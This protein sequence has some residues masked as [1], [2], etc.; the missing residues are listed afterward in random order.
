MRLS[1]LLW[2]LSFVAGGFA[3]VYYTIIRE[4]QLPLIAEAIRGVDA[5]RSDDVY[6]SAADIVYWSGFAIMVTILLIQITLLVSF[7][8]RR[9][10]IRWWQL[11]TLIVQALLFALT[12][13]LV[14]G[15]EKGV[16]LRQLLA[17]QCGLV[18]LALLIS[19]FPAAIHWTARQHD[20]RR[21]LV[22][23]SATD[24]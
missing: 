24:L 13:E 9:E 2:V 8:S 3:V 16:L 6:T 18:L 23:S 5:T 11:A 17:G 1:Q 15:G 12:L 19:T 4:D 14:A 20:V 7:M 21:G 22:G 10:G